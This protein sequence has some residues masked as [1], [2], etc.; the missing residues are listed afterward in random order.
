MIFL[1]LLFSVFLTHAENVKDNALSF[2]Y[3]QMDGG[4]NA[5]I[6]GGTSYGLGYQTYSHINWVRGFI[7][8]V[9]EYSN[10]RILIDDVRY[11]STLYS[12]DLIT[13]IAFYSFPQSS[14]SPFFEISL[15]GGFKALR[16]PNPPTGES[17]SQT[18]LAYG[19]KLT[20][21]T[22]INFS[23]TKSVRI[24]ST[25]SKE[26]ASK[27]FNHKFDFNSLSFNLGFV[28]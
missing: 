11:S 22:D 23:R 2:S 12:T 10:S 20:V 1:S 28:F 18:E 13:G 17:K 5:S 4:A 9:F 14:V 6:D 27:L 3:A 15:V 19:Y 26:S 21:G 7:G 8:G 25:L 24:S 16:L